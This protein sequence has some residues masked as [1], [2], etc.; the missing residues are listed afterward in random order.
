MASEGEKSVKTSDKSKKFTQEQIIA[1]FNKLRQEQ[2]TL[3]SRLTEVEQDLNEHSLV[4][5][6]LRDVNPERVCYRMIG[7][8]LVE[9]TVSNVLPAVA[10]N[11]EQLSKVLEVLN[12]Q[13]EVK[14]KEINEFKEKYNIQIRKDPPISDSSKEEPPQ[15]SSSVLVKT[16]S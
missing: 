8:I 11:K 5:D 7:G 4:V 15:A 12:K 3:V 10:H 2:K 9:R 14:G 16:E 13:I 6:A 1:T